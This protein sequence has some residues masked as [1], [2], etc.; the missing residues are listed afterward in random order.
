M[1]LVHEAIQQM[2]SVVYSGY[3]NRFLQTKN[4]GDDDEEE[5]KEIRNCSDSYIKV[6]Q[7]CNNC[8]LLFTL[9]FILVSLSL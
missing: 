4:D 6:F 3:Y 9:Q 8:C 5:E 1:A 2:S 7:P